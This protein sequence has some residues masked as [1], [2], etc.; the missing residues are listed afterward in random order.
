VKRSTF[1]TGFVAVCAAIVFATFA[2]REPGEPR[3]QDAAPINYGRR[4]VTQ[5]FAEIGPEV[6]EP[7]RRFM[8]N[9]LACQS[10]HLDG[11]TNP[12]A[13]PLADAYKTYPKFHERDGRV[14][15]VV[16][17]VN[18]CMTR[19]MN[20][21][22]LPDGSREMTARHPQLSWQEARDVAAYIRSSR[23][24][25]YAK[26]GRQPLSLRIFSNPGAAFAAAYLRRI[27]ASE[28]A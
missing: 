19:S 9:N 14:I 26:K 4:L 11:G 27:S 13:L 1:A 28:R 2:L 8:G 22:P 10:C 3:T 18:E 7:A 21:R 24:R 6:T 23:G 16:E 15:S 25:P 17:R 20:G 12:T 5:T